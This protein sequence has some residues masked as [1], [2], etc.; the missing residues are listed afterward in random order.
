M[1]RALAFFSTIPQNGSSENGEEP[2]CCKTVRSEKSSENPLLLWLQCDLIPPQVF[3]A[4]R[5]YCAPEEG[6]CSGRRSKGD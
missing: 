6:C 1:V 2:R 3:A 5:S 4:L